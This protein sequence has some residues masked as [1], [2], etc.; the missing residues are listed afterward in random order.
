MPAGSQR[1]L[2]CTRDSRL[3]DVASAK[4]YSKQLFRGTASLWISMLPLL[5]AACR[6]QALHETHKILGQVDILG[7]PI[8]L[9]SS[10]VVGLRQ[11]ITEPLK[12]HNPKQFVIG[13]GHGTLALAKYGSFG[14]L[15]A[16]EQV[17]PQLCA[18]SS[19]S[20]CMLDA[21]R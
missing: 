7:S 16:F 6:V 3:H 1:H 20:R 15:L 21:T 2:L 8:V 13:L 12:A 18:S 17:R 10:L 4:D 11:F 19:R 5:S 14:L 9:G